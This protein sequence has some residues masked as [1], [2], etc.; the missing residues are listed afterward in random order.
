MARPT[1]KT[2]TTEERIIEAIRQGMTYRLAAQYGGIADSTLRDWLKRGADGDE[3]FV[4]FSAAVRQA[5]AEGAYANLVA[6]TQSPDWRARA[7]ILEHRHPEEFG[8]RSKL[9]LSGDPE[10]PVVPTIINFIAPQPTDDAD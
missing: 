10:R 6:I 9:E 8:A 3:Q 7:W 4:A 5:E 2:P 1:K